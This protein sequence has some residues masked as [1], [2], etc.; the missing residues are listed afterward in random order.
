MYTRLSDGFKGSA[1][2]VSTRRFFSGRPQVCSDL[3]ELFEGGFEAFNDRLRESTG[4]G[5]VVGIFDAFVSG[6]ED[7]AAR[8]VVD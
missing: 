6:P 1:F 8:L 3:A 5:K 7:V 4:N 2:K